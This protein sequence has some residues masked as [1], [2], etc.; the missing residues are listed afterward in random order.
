MYIS[1]PPK[2]D[3]RPMLAAEITPKNPSRSFERKLYG[4]LLQ[5]NYIDKI[6]TNEGLLFQKYVFSKLTKTKIKKL[7]FLLYKKMYRSYKLQS[8]Y[9]IQ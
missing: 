5:Y 4:D 8:K 2:F 9:I 3:C 6:V 7:L 1:K